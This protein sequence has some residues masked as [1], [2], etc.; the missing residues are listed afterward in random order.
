MTSSW[1][2]ASNQAVKA[3][4]SALNAVGDDSGG[5]RRAH[6]ALQRLIDA[7]RADGTVRDDLAV[8]DFYLLVSNAPANQT[9]AILDRW[10]EVILFGI[11][12]RIARNKQVGD[13]PP[14]RTRRGVGPGSRAK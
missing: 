6:A 11:A 3:A 14:A 10:V 8:D 4:A 13:P 5:V 12:G 1:A 7:A 2:A 9:P